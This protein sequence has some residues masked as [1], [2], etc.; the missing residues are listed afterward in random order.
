M[1]RISKGSHC[2]RSLNTD[3]LNHSVQQPIVRMD[4]VPLVQRCVSEA[5]PS[6]FKQV[7][8]GLA[9]LSDW[10]TTLC[11]P[12]LFPYGVGCPSKIF[13]TFFLKTKEHLCKRHF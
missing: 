8:Q 7:W 2:V 11:P 12:P 13:L 6:Q 4:F 10:K 3:R 1:V 5:Q 9:G